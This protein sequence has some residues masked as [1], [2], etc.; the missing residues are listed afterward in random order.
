MAQLREFYRD[1]KRIVNSKS[2]NAPSWFSFNEGLCRNLKKWCDYKKTGY[3]EYNRLRF[4]MQTQF[5]KAG[6]NNILP[7]NVNLFSHSFIQECNAG[8]C[9]KNPY[10]LEWIRKHSA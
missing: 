2:D 5:I 4:R 3:K 6:Y 8:K 9:Y 1:V 10:R 7:F